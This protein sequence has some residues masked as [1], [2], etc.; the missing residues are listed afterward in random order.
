MGEIGLDDIAIE[1]PIGRIAALR[2]AGITDLRHG[3]LIDTD[4]DGHDR[5][6]R[7]DRRL[8]HTGRVRH[9]SADRQDRRDG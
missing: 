2:S 6:E 4:W 5:F 7:A 3:N 9:S 1:I 8:A